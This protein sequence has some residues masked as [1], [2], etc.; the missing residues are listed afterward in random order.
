MIPKTLLLILDGYGLAEPS[1]GNAASL[2]KTPTLNKLFQENHMAKLHAS[3]EAVGLPK[4]FIGNSEVGHLNIGAGRVVLQDMKAIDAAIANG[5]FFKNPA[6]LEICT[7]IKT[8]KGRLHLMGLLSDGGVHSHINH[9]SALLK[10]AKEQNVPCYLHAF[11][12]GRDTAPT[13]GLGFLQDIQKELDAY[14]AK[15]ASISG[16]FYAMDRDK[17]WDRVEKAWQMLVLGKGEDCEGLPFCK[18]VNAMVQACYDKDM[19]DEFILPHLALEADEACV[20]DGDG[21]FFFNFRA[22]RARELAHTFVDEEFTAFGR[23][24]RPKLSAIGGMTMYEQSLPLAV[25][26]D[27]SNVVNTLGEIMALRGYSQ[28][29]IAETEKYAHVTYFLNGGAEDAFQGE[30]RLLVASP[31][32]V[33]TYDLKP[34]MSAFEVTEK[35]V[36][37]IKNQNYDFI[38]CNLAN[39]DMVG[40]TGDIEA[41]VKACEVVDTCVQKI[42]ETILSVGGVLCVTADHGNVEEMISEDGQTQ[43]A[44]SMNLTPL[45][46]ENEKG[47]VPLQKE[48]KLGDIA[49]TLLHLWQEDIPKEMTGQSLLA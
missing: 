11:M 1:L 43:T 19:G 32:D 25:A 6:L 7:K 39:P 9:I 47:F 3:G 27:K 28:L 14:G 21:I 24:R 42:E 33:A 45:V 40:H 8:Q 23:V 4:G 17:R 48:G 36:D 46:I 31:K 44:H 49:P 10:L 5:E 30:D 16:R 37:A 22:D 20:Q 38:V 26:F 41:S 13:S 15:L 29:R 2:A 18:D 12:D 34:Q 35:L